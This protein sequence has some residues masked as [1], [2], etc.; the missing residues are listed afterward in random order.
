MF[1]KNILVFILFIVLGALLYYYS[2]KKYDSFT[3]LYSDLELNKLNNHNFFKYTG[4]HAAQF[5]FVNNLPL[6]QKTYKDNINLNI[7]SDII[8]LGNKL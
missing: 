5:G 7:Y 4:T 3:L 8:Y 2:L 1:V 6:P